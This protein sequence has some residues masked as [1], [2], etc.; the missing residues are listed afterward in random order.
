MVGP[1]SLKAHFYLTGLSPPRARQAAPL[2]AFKLNLL[3]QGHSNFL[4]FFFFF[5]FF[6]F[7][8]LSFLSF[9]FQFSDI[10]TMHVRYQQ[11]LRPL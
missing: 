5:F 4:F 3:F 8:F 9:F 11:S 7:F 1:L 10:E 6:V 2:R